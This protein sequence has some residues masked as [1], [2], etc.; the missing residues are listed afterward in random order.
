MIVRL[1]SHGSVS[2]NAHCRVEP[3]G[4]PAAPVRRTSWPPGAAGHRVGDGPQHR[5]A[6]LAHRLGRQRELAVRAAPQRAGV[7]QR[8]LEPLQRAGVDDRVGA[9]LARQLVQVEVVQLGALVGLRELLRQGVE[10]GEVLEHA[11]AVAE[12][13]PVLAVHALA[14]RP[15]PRRAAGTR[16]L[17]V[18]LAQPVDQVGDAERLLRE[19]VELVAL[20]L[21]HRVP[22]ALR[23]G[24][25]VGQGVEELVEVLRLLGEVV[26]VLG[27]EVVE[28]LLGVLAARAALAAAR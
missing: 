6:E 7:A 27:H 24:G 15:S 4:S 17:L 28:L 23:G 26:A 13:E 10:V 8:L 3:D 11:G 5:L 14:S 20:L 2:P 19:R 9:E 25:P 12:P 22:H 21:R 1:T 16:R 18:E